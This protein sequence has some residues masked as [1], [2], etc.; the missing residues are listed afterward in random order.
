MPSMDDAIDRADSLFE[1][2]PSKSRSASLPHLSSDLNILNAWTCWRGNDETAKLPAEGIEAMKKA[3]SNG[4]KDFIGFFQKR[5][6]TYSK[7][8]RRRCFTIH[9]SKDHLIRYYDD[10]MDPKNPK[11]TI[12]INKIYKIT[13]EK[14]DR[15]GHLISFTLHTT[16]EHRNLLQSEEHRDFHLYSVNSNEEK[17]KK[18]KDDNRDLTENDEA[19]F[20][21]RFIGVIQNVQDEIQ[22]KKNRKYRKRLLLMTDLSH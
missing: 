10:E 11:G 19:I 15:K 2:S 9:A 18:I 21:G 13:S 5:G 4:M 16:E 3:R 1:D 17:N 7:G 12:D 6:E 8:R 14:S 20:V 22:K